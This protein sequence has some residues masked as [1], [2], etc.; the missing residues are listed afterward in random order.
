MLKLIQYRKHKEL[1]IITQ[2]FLH[3]L[4]LLKII[5]GFMYD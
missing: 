3:N 4:L 5:M 2:E 1:T